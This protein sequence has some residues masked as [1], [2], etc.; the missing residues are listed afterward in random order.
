MRW[1]SRV[2]RYSLDLVVPDDTVAA[3]GGTAHAEDTCYI[4]RG[5]GAGASRAEALEQGEAVQLTTVNSGV[6]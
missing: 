4:A 1:A 3:A 5:A 2:K 6:K